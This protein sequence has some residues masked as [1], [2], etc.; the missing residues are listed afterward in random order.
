MER[1]F[2][3]AHQI[4]HALHTSSL[5]NK[6]NVTLPFVRQTLVG[7]GVGKETGELKFLN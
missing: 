2:E 3:K 7:L 6:R 5:E 4:V 1:S